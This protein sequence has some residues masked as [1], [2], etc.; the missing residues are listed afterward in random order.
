MANEYK[1]PKKFVA[2]AK[3]LEKNGYPDTPTVQKQGQCRGK[4][5]AEKGT[6]YG[7]MG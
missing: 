6:S 7:K 3:N 5:A 2:D 1:K 4:G